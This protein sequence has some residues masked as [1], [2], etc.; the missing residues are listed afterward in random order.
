MGKEPSSLYPICK[1][2]DFQPEP[3]E[4]I[5]GYGQFVFC[6]SH[7]RCLQGILDVFCIYSVTSSDLPLVEKLRFSQNVVISHVFF[8]INHPTVCLS[9]PC[10][11]KNSVC[12]TA[13]LWNSFSGGIHKALVH[14]LLFVGVS[15]QNLESQKFKQGSGRKQHKS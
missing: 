7:F 15:K 14:A 12:L 8:R 6:F 3:T 5:H 4:L 11:S 1:V 2:Y 9:S 10:S 13:C